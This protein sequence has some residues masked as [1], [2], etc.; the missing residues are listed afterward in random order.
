[1]RMI[2]VGIVDY[3]VG[4][5]ASVSH[6]MRELGYRVRIGDNAETLDNVDVL[7]LPGVGAFPQAMRAI[8]ELG[9]NIYIKEQVSMQRPLIGI[10]LGMQLLA[11]ESFEFG[12][13]AG[14]DIIP[15]KVVPLE[16]PCWHI[17][18]NSIE[19]TSGDP[20]LT[21]CDGDDFYFNHSYAFEAPKEYVA[22]VS[23]HGQVISAVLRRGRVA[24]VQF[25]PEKSQ[26][27]GKRLIKCLIEGLCHA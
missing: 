16:S 12:Q 8:T 26:L 11:T 19:T 23:R 13:T 10:C 15:G 20:I 2:T 14:L 25:H 1:M 3:G 7:V 18:W 27:T 5:H 9:L 4:N 6:T 17:G 22:A 24:G 21:P